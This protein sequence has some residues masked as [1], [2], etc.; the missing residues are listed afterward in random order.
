[1]DTATA[2]PSLVPPTPTPEEVAASEHSPGE[3]YNPS[4]LFEFSR[5][6]H[7]GEGSEECEHKEDGK[8]EDGRH[9]HAWCR[10]PNQFQ[11]EAIREKAMAAKARKIR[12]LKDPESDAHT[13]L[14]FALDELKAANDPEGLVDE[15]L[16]KDHMNVHLAA[17]NELKATEE[18]AH[19]DDDEE[20]A[21]ALRNESEET[22][23]NEELAQLEK[24][25][26]E[27]EEQVIAKRQEVEGPH[28][29]GLMQNDLDALIDMVRQDRIERAGKLQFMEIFSR[30]AWFL[31][32]MKKVTVAKAMDYEETRYF[33]SIKHLEATADE[34]L[35]TLDS[36]FADL[37]AR[38]AAQGKGY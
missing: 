21:R 16:K 8:C 36:V 5:W 24:H 11:H 26:T 2:Q 34:V 1:M 13:I 32:T 33:A 20:R 7:I 19:I 38:M 25:L 15:I 10:I 3:G 12:A 28:R 37:E 30:W 22:R 14:E 17:V 35:N 18:F 23:N 31:G 9:F 4:R 29:E 6:I 27:F